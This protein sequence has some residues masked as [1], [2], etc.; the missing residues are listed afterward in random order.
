MFI[1]G[2]FGVPAGCFETTSINTIVAHSI[3]TQDKHHLKF[4]S[5]VLPGERT[6]RG[7]CL[8]HSGVIPGSC[9]GV[10]FGSCLTHIGGYSRVMFGSCLGH[11]FGDCRV[12]LGSCCVHHGVMFGTCLGHSRVI[13]WDMLG[14]I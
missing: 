4:L 1:V 12:N 14:S 8:D 9:F 6:G 2:V 13:F 10:L 5:S 7:T 3:H 11:M